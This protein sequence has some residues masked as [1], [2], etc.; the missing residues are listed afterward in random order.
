MMVGELRALAVALEDKDIL[1]SIA[2]WIPISQGSCCSSPPGIAS[3]S[4]PHL[5]ID[6]GTAV[7]CPFSVSVT[8]QDKHCFG[9]KLMQGGQD[10]C[11][12]A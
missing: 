6:T 4:L 11:H 2:G 5:L 7:I 9:T 8:S 1:G 3:H 10:P 12:Q